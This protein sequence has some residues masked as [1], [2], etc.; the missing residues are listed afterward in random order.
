MSSEPKFSDLI[1]TECPEIVTSPG[2]RGAEAGPVPHRYRHESPLAPEDEFGA[3][4]PSSWGATAKGFWG[5]PTTRPAIP[6]G[7]YT[8]DSH[9]D[10]GPMLVPQRLAMDDLV[11]IPDAAIG[12]LVGEFDSF[13]SKVDEF[14]RRGFLHK[15]GFL[16]WG[17]PA[18][19]K[20]SLL[21]RLVL[22]LVSER[23]GVV[24]FC[25]DPMQLICCIKMLRTIEPSR[26]LII[27]MEDIDAIIASRGESDIL[28]LLDGTVQVDHILCIATTNYPERLDKRIVNRPSRFDTIGHIGMPSAAARRT[29]LAARETVLAENPVELDHW[30]SLSEGFSLAHLKEMIIAVF[31]L[32]QSL[33]HVVSRLD[34]MCARSPSSDD[35]RTTTLGFSAGKHASGEGN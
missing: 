9:I 24:V 18:S 13:W 2:G 28:A 6:A 21:N 17:P 5:A 35:D 27:I 8:T 30:V 1:G 15:R 25:G 3:P 19:G 23:D 10:F 20:T 33:E 22:R 4:I 14:A 31:C 16:L 7:T 34:D 12:D 32:G 11:E 29:Y 26:P